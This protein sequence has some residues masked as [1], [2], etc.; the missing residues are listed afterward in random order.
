MVLEK[1]DKALDKVLHVFNK[2]EK[3]MYSWDW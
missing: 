1:L 3:T 2:T